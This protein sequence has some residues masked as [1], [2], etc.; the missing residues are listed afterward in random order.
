VPR[1]RV[2]EHAP[3]SGEELVGCDEAVLGGR[4]GVARRD[5]HAPPH[6]ACERHQRPRIVARSAHEEPR[7]RLEGLDEGADTADLH[8]RARCRVRARERCPC[9]A[10][11]HVAKRAVRK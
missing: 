3:R 4:A 11:E 9:C 10:L 7:R 5:R 2:A 6:G 8:A 1:G